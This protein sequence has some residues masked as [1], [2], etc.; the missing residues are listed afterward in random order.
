[1]Q[2]ILILGAT[3]AIAS[4]MARLLAAQ[5]NAL[6]LAARNE[7]ALETLLQ[8]IK[9]RGAV[10]VTGGKFDALD[11]A[12]HA[13]LIDKAAD[14]LGGL[15]TMIMAY[16]D[17][18]DQATIENS[19][20]K[21]VAALHTNFVSAAHILTLVARRFEQQG[22]GAIVAISSVAGDRGRASNYVY[23]SAKAGLTCFL[24][25]MRQRLA[26]QGVK[27]VTIKPGL[28]DTP[29]TSGFPKGALWSKPEKV[30]QVA[31]R[32]LEGGAGVVYAPSYWRLIMWIIRNI[33]D[34]LF[35]R[36]RF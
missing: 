12:S 30:A 29:M 31:I 14:A 20:E 1:M 34:R 8:D 7:V 25:G 6:F 10:V 22:R 19:P 17:L 15:D 23:G 24:S 21:V 5:G 2:K 13:T 32:A 16:G 26:R 28:V 18:P 3:S 33:P 9:A 35:T 11:L 27:V 4:A 36:L